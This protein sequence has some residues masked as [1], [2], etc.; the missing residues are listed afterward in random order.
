MDI[1]Y[2]LKKYLRDYFD[3]NNKDVSKMS[4]AD[5][6][7]ALDVSAATVSRWIAPDDNAPM[8]YLP[9]IAAVLNVSVTELL[10]IESEDNLSIEERTIINTYRANENFKVISDAFIK[11]TNK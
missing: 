1:K 10:G 6:S 7:K 4:Q 9:E 8:G 11:E 2:N 3:K 5:F